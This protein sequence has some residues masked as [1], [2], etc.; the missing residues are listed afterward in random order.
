MLTSAIVQPAYKNGTLKWQRNKK[1]NVYPPKCRIHSPCVYVCIPSFTRRR[2]EEEK[3][4]TASALIQFVSRLCLFRYHGIEPG[5]RQKGT[6][7]KK[8]TMKQ[9]SFDCVFD[10]MSK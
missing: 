2:W 7:K 8:N 10:A 5:T 4:S 9:E 6:E 1:H 3:L